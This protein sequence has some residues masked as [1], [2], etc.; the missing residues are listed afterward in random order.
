MAKN[1]REG[2]ILGQLCGICTPS[3]K[4]RFPSYLCGVQAIK[5]NMLVCRV[6]PIKTAQYLLTR[7]FSQGSFGPRPAH[8]M[9]LSGSMLGSLELCPLCPW[10]FVR[11][12]LGLSVAETLLIP[13]LHPALHTAGFCIPTVLMNFPYPMFW[14]F[15]FVHVFTLSPFTH[16]VYTHGIRILTRSSNVHNS[17]TTERAQMS[18]DR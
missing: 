3:P 1:K 5:Q 12:H 6:S 8:G 9:H 2:C 7:H 17:Q 4:K 16:R 14:S 11:L 15:I 10:L 13:K 18:I